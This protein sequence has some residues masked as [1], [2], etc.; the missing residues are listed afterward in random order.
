[1]HI[2]LEIPLK[3]IKFKNKSEQKRYVRIANCILAL[4]DSN[5]KKS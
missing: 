1:M 3:M 2:N 5:M 4:N